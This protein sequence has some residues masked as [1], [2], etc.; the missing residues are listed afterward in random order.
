M[1]HD[2]AVNLKKLGTIEMKR[3]SHIE[4]NHDSQKWFVASALT[5]RVLKDDFETRAEA[6]SWE[7]DW[8]SPGGNGW[9]EIL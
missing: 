6:L 7:K 3:A 1:L 5:K 2:D 9:G 8:Y 4:F